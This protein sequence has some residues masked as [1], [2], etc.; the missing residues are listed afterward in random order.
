MSYRGAST[1][2]KVGKVGKGANAQRDPK[3]GIKDAKELFLKRI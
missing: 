1:R 2:G 3:H